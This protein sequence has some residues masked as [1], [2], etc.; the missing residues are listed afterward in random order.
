[1]RLFCIYN[2]NFLQDDENRLIRDV[3]DVAGRLTSLHNQLNRY[4]YLTDNLDELRINV[5]Q[6]QVGEI[7]Q[8]RKL[9]FY[10]SF[11]QKLHSEMEKEKLAIKN[12]IQRATSINPQ[13]AILITDLEEKRVEVSV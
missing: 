8:K 1:M 6:I 4:V 12:L 10:L 11:F 3:Y 13:L 5:Q 2:H 7:K 9:F